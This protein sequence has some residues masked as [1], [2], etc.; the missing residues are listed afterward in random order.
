MFPFQVLKKHCFKSIPWSIPC[1]KSESRMSTKYCHKEKKLQ[2]SKHIN[3][4]CRFQRNTFLTFQ[5]LK[6]TE[7]VPILCTKHACG[8]LGRGSLNLVVICLV[9]RMW[10]A[11]SMQVVL[12]SHRVVKGHATK[13]DWVLIISWVNLSCLMLGQ[14][15]TGPILGMVLQDFRY[16]LSKRCLEMSGTGQGPSSC[17]AITLPLNYVTSCRGNRIWVWPLWMDRNLTFVFTDST[18]FREV[19]SIRIS[20]AFYVICDIC[21]HG[22]F[23]FFVVV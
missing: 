15:F 20:C 4:N 7:Y 3:F 6:L 18:S 10:G 21:A 5:K 11:R 9:H 17:N 22:M 2:N 12:H 16:D 23:Y 19:D 13:R 14:S 1:E 8:M